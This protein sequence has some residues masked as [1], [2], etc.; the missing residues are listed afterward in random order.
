M[1]ARPAP[2]TAK[3]P[4][5]IVIGA[6]K[7]AT[8]WA[9]FQLQHHPRIFMP[10]PEPHFFSTEYHRGRN[11]YLSWF[12]DAAPDQIVG[13]KSADYLAHPE[14]PRRIADLLPHVRLIAQLRNPVDRAYSDYCMLFRRGEVSANLKQYLRNVNGYGARFLEGG[15]YGRHLARFL[16]HFP[17]EQMLIVLHDEIRRDPEAAVAKVWKH[18]DIEPHF[19]EHALPL[20]MKDRRAPHL[21]LPVRRAL[22]PFKSAVVPFRDQ[23]WFEALRGLVARP[24]PYPPLTGDLRRELQDYYLPDI[25]NLERILGRPL[26]DWQTEDNALNSGE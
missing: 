16:D 6:I 17:R 3:F 26:T 2:D 19:A 23:A 11:W 8:T 24:V 5:F 15:L 7:A 20:K 9:S 13:E 18:L 12:K 25:Q 10:G 4:D 22:K 1:N 21:P 14:A